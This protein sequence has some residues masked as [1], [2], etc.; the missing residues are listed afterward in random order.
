MADL[1]QEQRDEYLA[2]LTEVLKECLQERSVKQGLLIVADVETGLLR[3]YS[4]NAD[5]AILPALLSA[6]A[7]IIM[8]SQYA[9]EQQR[10]VN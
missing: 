6:A 7:Q 2:R 1:T 5:E 4:I 10:T 3:L 8:P 9:G